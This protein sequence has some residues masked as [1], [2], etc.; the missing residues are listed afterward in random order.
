MWLLVGV[1]FVAGFSW[2]RLRAESAD[3]AVMGLGVVGVGAVGVL[4]VVE[5]AGAGGGYAVLEFDGRL[6]STLGNPSVLA[7]F[8]LLV[9]PLCAAAGVSERR[10]RWPGLVG[11][12][13]AGVML[14]G[15]QSRG[16]IVAFGVVG[17]VF[18]VVR[19]SMR[20]RYWVLAGVGGLLAATAAIGRWGELGF[21]SQGAGRD[22]GSRRRHSCRPPC[23]GRWP[24]D[25]PGRTLQAGGRRD[26]PGVREPGSG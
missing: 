3:M 11:C 14:V 10:W 21:G 2:R 7:S 9:G 16:A 20:F 8:V 22:L 12:G 1:A 23:F 24:G 25:V 18:A 4:A 13:L 5:A 17:L 19:S 15:S 26:C 6:R